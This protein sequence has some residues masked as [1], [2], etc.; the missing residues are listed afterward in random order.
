MGTQG[1]PRPG[2]I[3]GPGVLGNVPGSSMLPSPGAPM[4]PG[5]GA[6]QG[7]IVKTQDFMDI[8]G[9]RSS[10]RIYLFQVALFPVIITECKWEAGPVVWVGQ[11]AQ[12]SGSWE[13]TPHLCVILCRI[14]NERLRGL[15]RHRTL[16]DGDVDQ[17]TTRILIPVHYVPVI[18]LYFPF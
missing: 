1:A 4:Q 11:A 8:F 16:G 6:P 13:V 3:S 7:K 14:W 17:N 9:L 18:N 5:A 10:F 15:G 2:Q 12:A